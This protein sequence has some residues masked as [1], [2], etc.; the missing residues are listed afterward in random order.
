VTP[1]SNAWR[2]AVRL[3]TTQKRVVIFPRSHHILTRDVERADVRREIA[4]FLRDF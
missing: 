3:G 4:H 2:V 1:V